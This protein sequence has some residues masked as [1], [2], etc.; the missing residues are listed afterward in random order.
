MQLKFYHIDMNFINLNNHQ[1]IPVSA[2]PVSDYNVF[3]ET[4]ISLIQ[5]SPE[6]HCVLYFGY[7]E[8]N[9]LHLICC[10]ADDNEHNIKVS[11]SV[12]SITDD[13]S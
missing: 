3:F 9:S 13:L 1:S 11:S 6:R 12:V 2:I 10:I 7:M 4:N 8:N 5:D